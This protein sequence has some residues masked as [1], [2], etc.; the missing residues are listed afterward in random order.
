MVSLSDIILRIKAQ[1]QTGGT[2]KNVESKAK[3]MGSTVSTAIGMAGGM[4]GY[5]LVNGLMQSGREAINA[6]NQLDYFGG[7]LNLSA[8]ETDKFRSQIDNLQ[9]D[10]RKVDMTAVG[11]TAESIAVKMDLPKE[12]LGDLT[13]M[14]ATLSSTFVGEGRTQEDAV[15]AVSDALDGQF[16]R[17]QEIGISEDKLKENG[18]N[19]NLEDQASLIDALNKTMDE[20]GY[21]QTAKDITSMDDAWTALT[22]SGGRL[23]ADV[24]VPLT[25]AF[26]AVTDAIIGAID[27]VKD[28]GWAQG[29]ILIG[30]LALGVGLLAGAI[31]GLEAPIMTVVAGAMPAFITSLYAAATALWTAEAPILPIIAILA[32]LAI[33][34][35]EVGIYFGWWKDIGSMVAAISDGVRRL[36]EAFINSPQVQGAIQM[37]QNALQQ[38][39]TFIQPMI[40]WIQT[41]WSNLFGDTGSSPDVVHMIIEAFQQLG[42]IAG[43]V[44]GYLQQGF[45]TVAYVLTPLWNGLSNIVGIFQQLMAGSISWESA[46]MQVITSIGM[47]FGNFQLRIAQL[48]LQIGQRLV[49]GIVGYARQIPGRL[50]AFLNQAALRLLVFGAIAVIRARQAGMRIFNGIVNYIRQLPGRVG[51]YMMQVPGRIASAAGAAVGAAMSLASQVVSAVTNGIM[52]VANAVYNEFINI[53]SRINDAVSGAVSAAAN[54]GSAIKDAVLNALHIASPGIIQKKIAIEFADIPGRIG[55]SAGYVYSAARDY[56]GNILRGFNAPQIPLGTVRENANYTPT[57]TTG[58]NNIYIVNFNKGAFDVDARNFTDKEAQAIL[59]TGFESIDEPS[60]GGL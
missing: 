60:P 16:K 45:Q 1:D 17:L 10:F 56:A 50:G 20:M 23:L 6:S 9:K 12:K 46:F 18:W 39:W 13:K 30:G 42:N 41:Q 25:P 44:F 48:V 32:A 5:D 35:Y 26:I 34:V 4:I 51:A 31:L 19:G 21:E 3:S 59:I 27:F 38:L 57:N 52:G 37:V 29:A 11:A 47:A 2:F 33:A 14:T 36:W 24:V 54:F 7:R 22:V 58:G 8:S 49:N 15:L 53:G 40:S 55:E 28:N 43:I